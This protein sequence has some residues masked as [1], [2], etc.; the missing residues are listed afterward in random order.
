MLKAT[1][2]KYWCDFVWDYDVIHAEFIEDVLEHAYRI[3]KDSPYPKV[4]NFFCRGSRSFDKGGYL[5]SAF[6]LP[7][8]SGYR[9]SL[10]LEK[11]EYYERVGSKKAVIV[12][13]RIDKYISP[14]V[15]DAFDKFAIKIAK[16]DDTANF[17]EIGSCNNDID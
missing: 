11:I 9:G 12:Y 2:K 1:F 3:Y 15:S 17:G 14:K 7:Q 6:A 16:N 5:E 4:S 8:K 13:S 10:W